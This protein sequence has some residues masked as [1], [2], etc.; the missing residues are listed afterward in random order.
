MTLSIWR[1]SH[2]SLAVS[3]FMFILI[4]AV[5]GIVLS[6]EPISDKLKPYSITDIESISVAETITAL[7]E[8][9]DEIISLDVDINNFVLASVVTKEGKGKTFYINPITAENIGEYI[10]KSEVFRFATS[11]H[12]SLFLKKTGRFFVGLTS[13]LL[14]LITVSGVVLIIKRQGSFKKFFSKIVN[15][16]P[17]Q[18]YHIVFGRLTLI[19][20]IIITLTGV[21]LSLEKFDILPNTILKH[22]VNFEELRK[23]PRISLNDF[24]IFKNTSLAEVR[25][26]EF[27]FSEDIEDYFIL[28]LKDNEVLV[29]QITGDIISEIEYPFVKIVS[30]YSLIIHTGKGSVWWSIVLL[31][32]SCSILFFIYSGFVMTFNRKDKNRKVKN[33]F[34]KYSAEYIIL[35]GS[36]TGSTYN[37]AISFY[38]SLIIQGKAVYISELNSYTNYKEAT[39]I[40]IFTSTYGQGDAPSNA[41][42]F[43][44]LLDKTIQSNTINY[45]IL[46]FG[47]LAYTDF[48]KFAIDIDSTL[49]QQEAFKQQ[50]PLY[51][52]NNQSYEEFILWAENWGK[53]NNLSLKIEK[54]INITKSQADFIVINKSELNIDDTYTI[55]LRS[56]NNKRFESGDLL[57]YMPED[58]IE[59]LYSIAKYEGDVLLSIKKHSLGV[60]SQYFYTQNIHEN[61]KVGIYKNTD[62]YFPNKV[63]QVLMISNGTGIAPFL[64]MINQAS[65]K[66]EIHLFWG[67]RTKTSFEIYKTYLQTNNIE[68]VFFAYSQESEKQ[69]IQNVLELQKQLLINVLKTRGV[70]MICGSVKMQ[71]QVL[72]IIEKTSKSELNMTLT[73]LKNNNQLKM[74]CY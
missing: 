5:T 69:Y 45:S 66:Q 42:G 14:F 70:I 36:E 62:F 10:P 19:P 12:R 43:E 34:K 23:S 11:L 28:E 13:F 24:P 17:H 33:K 20:I 52:I 6:F 49:N 8:K 16:S 1:Y 53:A 68:S 56:I 59:R 61:I 58:G 3:S 55:R 63:K 31:I 9:Y 72:D 38:E 50:L 73:D 40:I 65:K 74:D 15:E 44:K 32:A 64:G 51:K 60:V 4:A 18:Y 48:C 21:Y 37:F 7:N 54:P 67:G 30:Y 27:P 47:S 39:N 71:N 46:G 35:V 22:N 57:S 26:I 2:L 41:N 25:R 29:N